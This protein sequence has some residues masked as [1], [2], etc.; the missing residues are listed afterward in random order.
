MGADKFHGVLLE[1]KSNL[2][3]TKLW[4]TKQMCEMLRIPNE[5]AARLMKFKKK[6]S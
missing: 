5:D 1:F 6:N 3:D 4:N 2:V